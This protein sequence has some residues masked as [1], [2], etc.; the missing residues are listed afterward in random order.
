MP[1][2]VTD[3][4]RFAIETT[5][6]PQRGAPCGLVDTLDFPLGPPDGQGY[7]A[8]W[9]FGRYSDRYSG[10]H[11]GED[12]VLVGGSSLG[13]P[14]HSIGHGTVTYA[15]PLGWGIDQGVVIVRHVFTDGSTL[16]SFYG[17]LEPDSVKLQPGDCV[18]R[19]QQV[20]NVGKPR[21]QPHLHFEIRTQLPDAPGPGY[22]S[23]DPQL[24]GWK[25]PSATI[26]QYRIAHAPG[27]TWSR[28][29]TSTNSF[30]IGLLG[31][32]AAK[33]ETLAAID[34]QQLIGLDASDGHVR[35]SQSL[36]STVFHAAVDAHGTAV[37]VSTYSHTVQAFN[38]GGTPLWQLDLGQ[39]GAIMPLPDGGLALAVEQHLIGLSLTGKQLWQIDLIDPPADWI[40][41][42]DRL[43]FS[44][45]SDAPA[46]DSLDA[47]G[48]LSVVAYTG[49]QLAVSGD[50]VF[51]YNST[52][53]Y[54]L[55]SA[56]PELLYALGT[57]SLT[58]GYIVALP[59]GGVLV[60]HKSFSDRRLILLNADGSLR[61][62][63]SIVSTSLDP[64]KLF[65]IGER[66]YALTSEGDILLIDT[67]SGDA[68]RLF[69]GGSNLQLR[70]APW[71]LVTND[72]KA[73]FDFRG[74]EIVA[75]DL[76]AALEES[77][78]AQP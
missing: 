4:L 74:G 46:I 73:L 36:S 47:S 33:D 70:G 40:D 11:T 19:G 20:G 18:V 54:R 5:P 56:Q 63:R 72:G 50:Q 23:V 64:P 59:D 51:V 13:S 78:G 39:P 49:G 28:P 45:A 12:W 37:Y 44:T 60:S 52:G 27:V 2:L 22:W 32:A 38:L 1:L 21:G 3:T 7:I 43:I 76:Q 14:V 34:N 57:S 55:T 71:I 15:Q 6:V 75:I 24:A 61:W 9:I 25:P 53:I 30:G 67:I 68:R 58:T 62:D 42:A 41:S 16:L 65:N 35:W 17:H 8:R 26:W 31:V 66:T 77:M 48:Q 29:L 10:I 69:H